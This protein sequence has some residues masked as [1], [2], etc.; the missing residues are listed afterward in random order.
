MRLFFALDIPPKQRLALARLRPRPP[1]PGAREFR[2]V[3][4]DLYHVTLAFLGEQPESALPA[5]SQ[6][7]QAAA[8]EAPAGTL[9]L[10]APSG[11]GQRGGFRVLWVGLDGDIEALEAVH[12]SLLTALQ[13]ASIRVEPGSF[14]PHVTLA[15]ARAQ[16]RSV[17]G[18]P[19][20]P[21]AT[22][23][24]SPFPLD[25]FV[26]VRSYLNPDGPSYESLDRFL[27]RPG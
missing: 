25:A 3:A 1:E 17:P 5:L 2:W 13:A 9:R 21:A 4:P 11:F 22:L 19:W 23:P 12:R 18:F 10:G 16:V 26:L 20:P 6:A 27:L 7:D 8:A 14:S 24:D 15:R